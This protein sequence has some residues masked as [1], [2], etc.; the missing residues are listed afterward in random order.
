MPQD[1]TASENDT[2]MVSWNNELC[3]MNGV[4]NAT[5]VTKT[6]INCNN[7]PSLVS[8]SG[9]IQC[10]SVFCGPNIVWK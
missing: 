5:E 7:F 8:A 10:H 6:M 3:A 1:K 4:D 9:P 2:V